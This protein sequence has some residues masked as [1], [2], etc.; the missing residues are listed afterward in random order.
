MV[1]KMHRYH[2]F[3]CIDNMLLI[4]QYVS[5]NHYSFISQNP[6]KKKTTKGLSLIEDDPAMSRTWNLLIRSQRSLHLIVVILALNQPQVNTFDK[7]FYF[8]TMRYMAAMITDSQNK[9]NYHFPRTGIIFK[10]GTI[11]L[12]VMPGSHPQKRSSKE[13]EHCGSCTPR[14]YS[15]ASPFNDFTKEVG[16]CYVFEHASARDLITSFTR[17]TQVHKNLVCEQTVKLDQVLQI[18]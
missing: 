3:P 7:L 17:L 10:F 16:S 8:Y 11:V 4:N 9:W 15:K 5:S 6:V 13:R 14:S 2:C 18:A 12:V 1:L